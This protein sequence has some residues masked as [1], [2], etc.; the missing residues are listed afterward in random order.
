[1]S[2]LERHEQDRDKRRTYDLARVEYAHLPSMLMVDSDE[3]LVCPARPGRQA[4][5]STLSQYAAL[6]Q[7]TLSRLLSDA[8]A[9]ELM[10]TRPTYFG[11]YPRQVDEAGGGGGGTL[12]LR[13]LNEYTM[14]CM[15]RGYADKSLAD[16][17]SCWGEVYYSTPWR[18]SSDVSGKC[19][20][21]FAH[22]SCSPPSDKAPDRWVICVCMCVPIC[23]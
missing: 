4:A 2:T 15:Q 12:D 14:T 11:R 16:M 18:K 22:W 8:H 13:A 9:D 20:F 23:M 7:A 1:M 19:P 5:I 21:H 6:Q 10:F 17:L 3:L